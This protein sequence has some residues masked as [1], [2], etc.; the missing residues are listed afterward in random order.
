MPVPFLLH[1][2]PIIVPFLLALYT[3]RAAIVDCVEIVVRKGMWFWQ[4]VPSFTRSVPY[5]K[6][7]V[8][9]ARCLLAPS[10]RPD[11][12]LAVHVYLCVS[13]FMSSVFICTPMV[14]MWNLYVNACWWGE[15]SYRHMF[16]LFSSA[17]AASCSPDLAAGAFV[18]CPHASFVLPLH[19]HAKHVLS[20]ISLSIPTT[21]LQILFLF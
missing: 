16:A 8:E 9:Q 17:L 14:Y 20:F 11:T 15:Q 3:L 2:F 6:I 7:R 13:S 5:T 1:T 19:P 18:K 4:S 10:P 21:V 12:S